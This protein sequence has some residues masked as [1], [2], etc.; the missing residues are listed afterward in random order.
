MT[1]EIINNLVDVG[2]F[3][4]LSGG[5]VAWVVAITLYKKGWPV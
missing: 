5:A 2:F 3:I 4:F 1:R